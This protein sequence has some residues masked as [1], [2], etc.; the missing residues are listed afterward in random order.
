[1]CVGVSASLFF[2]PSHFFTVG[3]TELT[4]PHSLSLS[5]SLCLHRATLAPNSGDLGGRG[6]ELCKGKKIIK[7]GQHED[8]LKDR[9]TRQ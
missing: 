6:G 5:T 2:F 7:R 1:M 8:S 9:F 4:C 3:V